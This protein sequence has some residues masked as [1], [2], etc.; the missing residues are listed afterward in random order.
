MSKSRIKRLRALGRPQY[1]L[2]VED[3]RVFYDV[4]ASTV[5]VLA[6]AS[7]RPMAQAWLDNEGT[8]D[9]TA[10][11]PWRRVKDDFARVRGDLARRRKIV[12]TRHGRPAGGC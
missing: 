1:R 12:I 5:E 4:E 3:T 6:D 9:T 11:A 10:G 7:R 8:P 2:R